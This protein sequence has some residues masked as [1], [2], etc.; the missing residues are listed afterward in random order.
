[1]EFRKRRGLGAV[2]EVEGSEG[3]GPFLKLRIRSEGRGWIVSIIVRKGDN[4]PMCQTS[5]CKSKGCS[6]GGTHLLYRVLTPAPHD[7]AV[8]WLLV[9]LPEI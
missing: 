3:D 9:P 1:M 2:I 7:S 6:A 5:Q 8:R 4:G